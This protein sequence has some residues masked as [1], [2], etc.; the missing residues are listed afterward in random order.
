MSYYYLKY[1]AQSKTWFKKEKTFESEKKL[2]LKSLLLH[3]WIEI[4]FQN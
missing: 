4:H 3:V 2:L 1:V